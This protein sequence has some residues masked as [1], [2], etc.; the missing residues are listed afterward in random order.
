MS[1][2]CFRRRAVRVP[3]LVV[4]LSR[5]LTLVHVNMQLLIEISLELL[6]MIGFRQPKL[7]SQ[8]LLVY[9]ILKKYFSRRQVV[10]MISKLLFLKLKQCIFSA[11]LSLNLNCYRTISKV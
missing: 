9:Q 11:L 8:K 2:A 1:G 3:D 7:F 6:L 5:D 10:E 4:K